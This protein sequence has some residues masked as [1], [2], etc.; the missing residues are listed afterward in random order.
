VKNMSATSAPSV[1][2]CPIVSSTMR[3]DAIWLLQ[4]RLRAE[5]SAV[6]ACGTYDFLQHNAQLKMSPVIGVAIPVADKWHVLLGADYTKEGER[7]MAELL[8]LETY[9]MSALTL[10]KEKVGISHTHNLFSDSKRG[11]FW[12]SGGFD[13]WMTLQPRQIKVAGWEVAMRWSSGVARKTFS[14]TSPSSPFS[15]VL[16]VKKAVVLRYKQNLHAP[17]TES[18]SEVSLRK[19]SKVELSYIHYFS[20]AVIAGASVSLGV[21]LGLQQF[22]LQNNGPKRDLG[23]KDPKITVGVAYKVSDNDIHARGVWTK[24]R[25]E[26]G[27]KVEHRMS[28]SIKPFVALTA[29]TTDRFSTMANTNLTAGVGFILTAQ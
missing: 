14:F 27:V 20:E 10:A 4:N 24:E 5:P 21:G 17:S 9:H 15:N 16:D 8:R 23:L 22:S 7:M 13:W 12:L 25:Q 3:G 28:D 19:R 18:K 6:I 1:G 26:I 11:H 2:T 29:V